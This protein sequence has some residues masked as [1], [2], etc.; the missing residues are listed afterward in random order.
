MQSSSLSSS[1]VR[2]LLFKVSNAILY[3]PFLTQV[4]ADAA[5]LSS[6]W[7]FFTVLS[8]CAQHSVR[9]LHVD[10]YATLSAFSSLFCPLFSCAVSLLL[11]CHICVY[12][13]VCVH[14]WSCVSIYNLEITCEGLLVVFFFFLR[15]AKLLNP[16]NTVVHFPA[17]GFVLYV[18]L[19]DIL[20]CIYKPFS[21]SSPLLLST[22]IGS[23]A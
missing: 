20:L 5:V 19:R 17:N 15:L 2:R 1:Q 23:I 22:K 14:I 6:P 13:S 16:L 4:W 8:H 3:R 7:K 11:L 9:A 12:M 21:Q 18:R 10:I